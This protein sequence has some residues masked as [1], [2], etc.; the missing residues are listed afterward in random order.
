V[1]REWVLQCVLEL[2]C[3]NHP[4]CQVGGSTTHLAGWVPGLDW[5]GGPDTAEIHATP[6][7]P[8][9][10]C[11]PWERSGKSAGLLVCRLVHSRAMGKR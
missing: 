7:Q 3:T 9:H 1:V 4:S 6:S 8:H 11:D 5:E 2:A 10:E